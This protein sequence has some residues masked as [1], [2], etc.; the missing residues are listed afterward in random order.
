M[1]INYILPCWLKSGGIRI[2]V[3][4]ANRLTNK[5]HDI[6]LYY[7]IK[8]YD[9]Y[10][11]QFRPIVK[12]KKKINSLLKRGIKYDKNIFD[13]RC[14]VI[15]V[16]SIADSFIRNADITIATSWPTSYDVVNLSKIKGKKVYFI[17]DYETWNSNLTLVDYSY[18]LPLNKVT[19]SN[20]LKVLL[21]EKFGQN[22][23]VILNGINYD[24]FNC[25]KMKHN[26]KIKILFLYYNLRKK[27]MPFAL[28]VVSEI[29]NKYKEIEICSFGYLKDKVIPEYVNFYENPSDSRIVD[30]YCDSN[31]FI[32]TSL[33]EG[34]ALPPAEA[35]AC[36]TA[37][38]A[39]KS[40]AIPDYSEH[41]KTAYLVEGSNTSDFIYGIEMFINDSDF[42]N[43]VSQNAYNYIRQ[44]LNWEI[45][46]SKFESYLTEL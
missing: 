23:D 7:P 41:M 12:F 18:K 37:V 39:I 31:I 33:V 45:S 14:E 40:G 4:Y 32:Y 11:G 9:H 10:R 6:K 21:K 26:N 44:K 43:I 17:Q 30:L 29:H 19:I 16:K 8:G 35:M 20:Y 25:K 3:E 24:I 42:R 34:F 13:N 15:A 22:S 38:V 28:K 1:K 46:I 2:I 27:N 36:N 5:G